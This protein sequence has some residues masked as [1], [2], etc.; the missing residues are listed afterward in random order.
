MTRIRAMTDA[1]AEAVAALIRA[2]NL[3]EGY[4]PKLSPSAEQVGRAY[5]GPDRSGE[6]AVAE[7]DG[8]LVGYVT[9]HITY[10]TTHASRGAYVGDLF[11]REAHRRQGVGRRLLGAAAAAVRQ[12][13]GAHLWWTALPKNTAGQAFYQ[14]LGAKPETIIAYALT[15][16]AFTRLATDE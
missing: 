9:W 5:L 4:D 10:E 7:H 8:V 16:A 3:S 11:V 14:R 1:D 12:A 2:L 15:H 6:G 13:G